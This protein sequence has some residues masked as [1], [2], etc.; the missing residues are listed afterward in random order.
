MSWL[1]RYLAPQKSAW[2][3]RPDSPPASCFFQLIHLL[4]M[5][6]PITPSTQPAFAFI[7]FCCDEGIR[8]NCG[9]TGAVE[10]P[11][12][13]RNA[14]AKLP[15]QRA[16]VHCYDAGDITC[17][18]QGLE[19]AQTA[20]SEVI[21][22]LLQH[23]FTPIVLGGGHE[24]AWGHYQGITRS[25]QNEVG[26]VNV[27]AHLD[28]RPLLPGNK[29]SS[30]TSFLQMANANQQAKR[31]FHYYCLGLQHASN[32]A[33]LLK[34]AEHHHAKVLYADHMLSE[35]YLTPFIQRILSENAFLYLSLCLDVFATAYAPGVS[36]PQALGI[37][38]WQVIPLLRQLA[39][40]QK[41]LSYD[42]AE[43]SPPHDPDQRTAKLAANLIYEIIHH[44][45]PVSREHT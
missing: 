36:A 30:G 26:I 21:T 1:D 23:H 29:G 28:M 8:R 33:A 27:D 25:T 43:L 24:L 15:L 44:H 22:L 35:Q 20:L 2:Q 31:E 4:D 19:A 5:R 42:I 41:M 12:A 14:L 37:T 11:L 6:Q 32:T 40:S 45:Q 7:G 10:G 39:A 17:T 13:I 16:S 38:P 18:D 3:G 9:R 34:T